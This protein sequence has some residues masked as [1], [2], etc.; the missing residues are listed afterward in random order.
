MTTNFVT[1]PDLV[2]NKNHSVLIIDANLDDVETLARLCQSY[3]Q[4][5]NV[6]FYQAEQNQTEW[7]T[8][9]ATQ[10]DAI[11][12]NTVVNQ[13]SSM[14]NLLIDLPKT[15]WYGTDAG[16]TSRQH[17]TLL[18]YFVNRSNDNNIARPL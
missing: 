17:H 1:Y 12:V 13:L 18:D 11:I 8:Q 3:Y 15:Y 2:N 5:V 14:K 9:V 10:V 6:Y 7:L 4:A 16:Q